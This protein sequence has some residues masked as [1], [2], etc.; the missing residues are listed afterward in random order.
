MTAARETAYRARLQERLE[1]QPEDAAYTDLR[2]VARLNLL[3]ESGAVPVDYEKLAVFIDGLDY[4]TE[5]EHLARGLWAD[6]LIAA[7]IGLPIVRKDGA[8]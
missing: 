4:R 2:K 8:A 1:R 3:M 5:A 6:A 7:T